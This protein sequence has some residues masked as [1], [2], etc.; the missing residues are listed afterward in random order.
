MKIIILF[1]SLII[2]PCGVLAESW[3]INLAMKDNKNTKIPDGEYSFKLGEIPCKVFP[4]K[5]LQMSRGVYNHYRPMSCYI[6]E[7]DIQGGAL[8]T[9]D[10]RGTDGELLIDGHLVRLFR[11]SRN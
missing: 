9:T 1:I 3:G 8:W 10:G 7:H 2:I 4:E 6:G 5:I 11:W